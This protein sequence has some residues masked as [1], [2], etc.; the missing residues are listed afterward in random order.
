M[1]DLVS[2][3]LGLIVV[4]VSSLTALGRYFIFNPLRRE[5]KEATR[6]IQPF[7]NG[8]L[9]LPDV[10]RKLDKL[11]SRQDEQDAKLDLV[12]DLLRK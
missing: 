7:A 5:I 8:G 12:I 10:A 2:Q 4:V 11:E 1:L 6:P 3:V 9:A